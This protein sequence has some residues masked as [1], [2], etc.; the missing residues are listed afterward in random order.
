MKLK[1]VICALALSGLSVFG[2][3]LVSFQNGTFQKIFV[4]TTAIGGSRT[5]MSTT[6]NAYSFYIVYG[7]DAGSMNNTSSVVFNSTATAGL[8]A[9]NPN[10]ALNA[11]TPGTPIT[12]EIF[13]YATSA[14]SYANAIATGAA[15]GHS[16]IITTTPNGSPNNGVVIFAN[17]ADANHVAAFDLVVAPE[18]STIALGALGG[19]SLLFVRRR[20]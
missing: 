16:A 14:G 9:G 19:L 3:G 5:A 12:M 13:G 8:L 1:S 20:K 4:D 2:Q 6:A 17:T 11:A 15:A 10:F 18:P 7:A